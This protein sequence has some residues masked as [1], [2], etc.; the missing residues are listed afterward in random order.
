MSALG[1]KVL[2]SRLRQLA[3]IDDE[4]AE[5]CMFTGEVNVNVLT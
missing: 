4:A 5:I 2:T 3:C 1:S